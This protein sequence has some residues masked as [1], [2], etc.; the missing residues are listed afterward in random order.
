[1]NLQDLE[2][3]Y[4]ELGAEI[5]RLKQQPESLTPIRKLV[6]RL[7]YAQIYEAGDKLL[8]EILVDYLKEQSNEHDVMG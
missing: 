4:K 6:R 5:E 7:N 2:T 1:M 8:E 3:K